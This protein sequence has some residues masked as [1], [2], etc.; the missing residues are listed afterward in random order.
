MTL[1]ELRET[2][3]RSRKSYRV[4]IHWRGEI[5]YNGY[6]EKIPDNFG[7]CTISRMVKDADE[8]GA[9]ININV[10]GRISWE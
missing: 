4:I 7:G 6:A 3:E 10:K 1:D 9:F 5:I 8:L 2:C